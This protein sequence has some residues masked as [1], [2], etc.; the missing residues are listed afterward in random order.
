MAI[1]SL[2]SEEIESFPQCA[3]LF[4]SHKMVVENC[5]EKTVCEYL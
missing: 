5:S 4:A 3:R 2:K 1:S